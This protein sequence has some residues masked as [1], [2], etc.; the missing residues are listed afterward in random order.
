M[1]AASG[2]QVQLRAP[3]AP[4][5]R[6]RAS[7]RVPRS[8]PAAPRASYAPALRPY[9]IRKGDTLDSIAKKR[10]L[11]LKDLTQYNKTLTEKSATERWLRATPARSRTLPRTAKVE[12]GQTILL[13]TFKLSDVR[14]VRPGRAQR[15]APTD[16]PRANPAGPR[17]P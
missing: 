1:Q 10:G 7:A 12:P 8:L 5:L 15:A 9:T 6:A 4:A 11:T 17:D 16:T 3:C 2:L 13:P 14:A